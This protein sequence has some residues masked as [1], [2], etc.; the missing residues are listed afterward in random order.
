M[1]ACRRADRVVIDGF[2]VAGNEGHTDRTCLC[3]LNKY[4][5]VEVPCFKSIAWSLLVPSTRGSFVICTPLKL[6]FVLAK[7]KWNQP[8]KIKNIMIDE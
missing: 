1:G 3:N 7:A 8:Q 6:V 5:D 4:A 2:Q